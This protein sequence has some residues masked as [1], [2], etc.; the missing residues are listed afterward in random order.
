MNDKFVLPDAERLKRTKEATTTY[1][2]SVYDIYSY[3]TYGLKY[4]FWAGVWQAYWP[5]N[6][7]FF[8]L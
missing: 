4:L 5:V 6:L 8:G 3:L 7:G 1:C 2:L